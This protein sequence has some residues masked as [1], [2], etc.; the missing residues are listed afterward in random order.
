MRHV[1]ETLQ[2]R[3]SNSEKPRPDGLSKDLVL[4]SSLSILFIV[5]IMK[6]AWFVSVKEDAETFSEHIGR[7][8]RDVGISLIYNS[9]FTIQESR[10]V[11]YKP[12]AKKV[13][14]VSAQD[15]DTAIPVYKDIH[16]RE[17]KGLP[18]FP[19]QMENL[20]FME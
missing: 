1:I 14:P 15:P 11:K 10:G 13:V 18:V 6:S 5:E 4:D 17:L 2:R 7:L 16:I 20:K 3:E 19:K 8:K 9:V 12:V